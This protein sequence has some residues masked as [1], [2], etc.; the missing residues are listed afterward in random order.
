MRPRLFQ[1]FRHPPHFRFCCFAPQ[2]RQPVVA[3]AVVIKAFVRPLTFAQFDD[4]TLLEQAFDRAIQRSG[5]EAQFA[6]RALGDIRHDSVAMLV[7]V[8]QRDQNM[9]SLRAEGWH[10]RIITRLD[11]AGRDIWRVGF[12]PASPTADTGAREA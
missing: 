6:A 12:R 1:K 7:A 5:A 2:R 10:F 11:I 9:K 8:G 4:Q 3:A